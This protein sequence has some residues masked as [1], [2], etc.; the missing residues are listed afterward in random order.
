MSHRNAR[1][2]VHRIRLEGAPV[3]HVAK[4]MGISRQ[5]AHRWLPASAPR[6]TSDCSTGLHDRIEHQNGPAR[7]SKPQCS[8]RVSS[9]AV[10]RTGSAPSSEC[11]HAL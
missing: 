9:T 4:A 6:A 2:T 5:C 3:T 11:R 1:L 8:Q 7:R 10:G